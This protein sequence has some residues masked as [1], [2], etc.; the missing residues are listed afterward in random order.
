[1]TGKT[2]KRLYWRNRFRPE[3]GYLPWLTGP[4]KFG[5]V[6]GKN[7]KKVSSS[8]RTRIEIKTWLAHARIEIKVGLLTHE[9]K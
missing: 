5:S 6:I 1:V 7:T 8:N 3:T 4:Y 2:A 9:L